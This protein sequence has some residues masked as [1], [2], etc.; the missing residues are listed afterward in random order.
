MNEFDATE[1]AYRNGYKA[2]KAEA[3]KWISVKD[4]LPS[5]D[6]AYLVVVQETDEKECAYSFVTHAWFTTRP[7][8]FPVPESIGWTLLYEFYN[9][10]EQMRDY[11]THW[12][13][14]PEPPEVEE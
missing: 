6:G 8:S 12:M 1:Q 14:L 11:I 7:I 10:T 13:P 2:G 3:M 5:E 4:R 9:F